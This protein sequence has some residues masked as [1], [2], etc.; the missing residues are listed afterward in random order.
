MTAVTE[1]RTWTLLIPA[2]TT[3]Q[4]SN[5]RERWH[6]IAPRR[7]AW[8]EAAYWQAAAAKLPRGLTKVRIDVVLRFTTNRRRDAPNY[9][10]EVIKPCVD[11]LAPPKTAKTGKGERVDPGWGL[12]PDDTEEFVF[13]TE[14][15]IGPTVPKAEYP[16][17]LVE[18]TITDISGEDPVIDDAGFETERRSMRRTTAWTYRCPA[19]H[20]IVVTVRGEQEQEPVSYRA[21]FRD[22][23]SG[24]C[25]VDEV[26]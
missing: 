21:L 26:A 1:T 15:E 18:L 24:C 17:G 4:T 8:R 16:Y 22:E 9:H 3:M 19:R 25:R 11:A 12:I 10:P 20:Q 6:S 7:R 14:P 23:H 13:L 5:R 2:P